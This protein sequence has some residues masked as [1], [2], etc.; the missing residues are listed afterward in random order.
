LTILRN[1][2]EYALHKK[3]STKY[4]KAN[5]NST[6]FA[7][8]Y[9]QS[10]WKEQE[11]KAVEHTLTQALVIDNTLI[12]ARSLL[13][14][15]YA[16]QQNEVKHLEQLLLSSSDT[17]YTRELLYFLQKQARHLANTGRLEE[18]EK[19]WNFCIQEGKSN[20]I[21]NESIYCAQDALVGVSSLTSTEHWDAPIKRAREILTD[22]QTEPL[23]RSFYSMQILAIEA[24]YALLNHNPEDVAPIQSK[25]DSIA[26]IQNPQDAQQIYTQKIQQYNALHYTPQELQQWLEE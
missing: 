8:E 12:D 7:L 24:E 1:K 26:L 11:Y 17:V 4:H 2:E 16:E 20:G 18:A 15:L 13:A 23:L 21:H 22:P 5:P 10:L 9:A 19:Y 6:H 3:Q 25:L 14:K